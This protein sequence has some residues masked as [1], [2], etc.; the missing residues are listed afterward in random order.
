MSCD[1][2]AIGPGHMFVIE[3]PQPVRRWMADGKQPL[4]A[5]TKSLLPVKG[6]KVDVEFP[7]R[8]VIENSERQHAFHMTHIQA[9]LCG[10]N[11]IKVRCE[12]DFCG[13]KEMIKNQVL[14][15]RCACFQQSLGEENVCGGYQLRLDDPKKP[16]R[17]IWIPDYTC[18]SW[19]AEMTKNGRFPVGVTAA[20]LTEDRKTFVAFAKSVL[21][22][23]EFVN[24]HGG[25]TVIGWVRRGW[26]HDIASDAPL[27]R[28]DRPTVVESSELTYHLSHIVPTCPEVR[29]CMEL[30]ELKFD[31]YKYFN[32]ADNEDQ[33][34]GDE[35]DGAEVDEEEEGK[36]MESEETDEDEDELPPKRAKM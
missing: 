30:G 2:C 10:F 6:L 17:P 32:D 18:K 11:V 36:R 16:D 31:V 14:A 15:L 24:A 23:L 19:I 7:I 22:Q 27:F 29:S 28:N 3:D 25:W 33:A 8:K 35:R 12:G 21:A 9:I 5:T 4:L 34:A 13:A 26:V 20:R 1:M